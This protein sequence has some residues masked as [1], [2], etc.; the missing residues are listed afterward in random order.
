M[1]VVAVSGHVRS[2]IERDGPYCHYCKVECVTGA[3]TR[4]GNHPHAATRDH[5]VPRLYGGRNLLDNFVLACRDCNSGRNHEVDHCE[6]FRCV[7]VVNEFR[8]NMFAFA[9]EEDPFRYD[10][11][12]WQQTYANTFGRNSRP[13]PNL[14]FIGE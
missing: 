7:N 1:G 3:A 10:P 4:K 13:D 14:L 5:I 12:L 11:N 9:G 2:L 6:C 8:M